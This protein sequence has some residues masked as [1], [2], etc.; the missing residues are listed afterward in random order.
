MKFED[1][2]KDETN[3]F[4]LNK[5]EWLNN[6]NTISENTKITYYRLFNQTK[7]IEESKG[8]DIN[9]FTGDEVE[10]VVKSCQTKRSLY[11]AISSYLNWCVENDI[12]SYNVCDTIINP[13]ELYEVN[14]A[15][16]RE[17]YMNLEEF[18]KWLDGLSA[19]DNMLLCLYDF[20]D[21][22]DG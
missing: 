6:D 19:D 16:V 2:I 8:K 9:K 5:I 7:D 1:I 22:G 4:L 20:V 18:Y 13:K 17:Q 3:I 14:E 12:I 11:S 10:E 15:I 21:I